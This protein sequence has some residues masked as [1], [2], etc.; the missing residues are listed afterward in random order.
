MKMTSAR[1]FMGKS[2]QQSNVARRG[3]LLCY[4]AYLELNPV[5]TN[6]AVISKPRI[7]SSLS[8]EAGWLRINF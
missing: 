4:M 1:A 3:A 5:L 7:V 8:S 2:L 6:I